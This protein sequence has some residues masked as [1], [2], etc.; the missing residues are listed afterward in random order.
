MF[1]RSAHRDV[2]LEELVS[3]R[4]SLPR[5]K[6]VP[7][8]QRHVDTQHLHLYAV[9]PRYQYPLFVFIRWIGHLH[10][11]LLQS[12]YYRS[13]LMP[14]TSDIW[15]SSPIRSLVVSVY[16]ECHFRLRFSRPV[17]LAIYE[18][19]TPSYHCWKRHTHTH[20][21]THTHKTQLRPHLIRR[22]RLSGCKQKRKAPSLNNWLIEQN[23]LLLTGKCQ[24]GSTKCYSSPFRRVFS[25]TFFFL[26][27]FS[28]YFAGYAVCNKSWL[29]T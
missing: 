3:G 2:Y 22:S 29:I 25:R 1:H 7:V 8:T 14:R 23:S 4:F 18:Y 6:I 20:T 5:A 10:G 26:F 19:H 13:I 28:N 17:W 12:G 15:L 21:H 9:T 11:Y 27:L 24:T 16:W